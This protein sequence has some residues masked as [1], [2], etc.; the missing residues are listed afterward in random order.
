MRREIVGCSPNACWGCTQD[1]L[2]GRYF[3]SLPNAQL[4]P[5][6]GITDT[7]KYGW[8]YIRLM[9]PAKC[10]TYSLVNNDF[11]TIIF[12]LDDGRNRSNTL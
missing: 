2:R 3:S 4:F 7:W 12:A 11:E 9:L 8:H 5:M 6:R 10:I 1:D